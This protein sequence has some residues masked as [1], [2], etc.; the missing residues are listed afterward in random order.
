MPPTSRNP[1]PDDG[2][3]PFW[4]RRRLLWIGLGLFLAG[5]LIL[6]PFWHLVGQ[7][8]E[9]NYR[10]PSRLYGRIVRF[11]PRGAC[12]LDRAAAA[13]RYAGYRPAE[14]KDSLPAG[15]YRRSGDRLEVHSRRFVTPDG[16]RPGAIVEIRASRGRVAS[17][18]RDGRP[19]DFVELEPPVVASYYGPKLEERRPLRLEQMP[20]DL[21]NSVLAAEDD[22][23]FEHAG[24]SVRGVA[25]AA[26]V[27]LR[28]RGIRQGGST[29][30]QQLV[31]NLFLTQQRT[32]LRKAEEAVLAV[33]LET[34][35]DKREILESYLNEIYLGSSGGV[36]VLGMGAAARA[37]F[38]KDASD[39]DLAESATLA[40]MI[41]SPA[42]YS[43][44]AHPERSKERRD[45]VLRRLLELG[46]ADQARVNQAIEKPIRV[47]LEAPIRRRAP[48][49]SDAMVNEAGKRFRI[50]DLADA[51]FT[52]Y[53]TLDLRDQAAAQAAVDA[54]LSA[55]EAD[56]PQGKSPQPLEA[57]L[58]SVDPATGGILAYVGGRSYQKSQFDRASQ[59]KRQPGSAFKPIVYAQLFE[60]GKGTPA[61]F[62][63]DSPLTVD[64]A[65]KPWSPKND[66]GSFHGWVTVRHA[67]EHS[68]NPATA[69][70]GLQVGM[71]RVVDL[72]HAMGVTADMDPFPAVALGATSLAPVELTE[73]YATLAAG[74]V[75]PEIHGLAEVFDR[76]GK[77]VAGDTLPPPRR[78]LSPVAAYMV[79]TLLQGVVDRGTGAGV[80]AQGVDGAIAGKTG[81]TNDRRD[82]WFA[83]YS[84]DRTTVVWVGF[85][86]NS[87]THLSGARGALPLWARFI[88]AVRP[89]G[90][91]P[92]F[93]P[94]AGVRMAVIDP[95]TGLLAT[96][97]CPSVITEVF[98][99]GHVP[100]QLCDRHTDWESSDINAVDEDG[101]PDGEDS[102]YPPG[103]E[104]EGRRHPFRRWLSRVFGGPEGQP[105][106]PPGDDPGQGSPPPG[107]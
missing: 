57:A 98:P 64:M 46:L 51:G 92:P 2:A 3:I 49:F 47:D 28:G 53:S 79:T 37:F 29:L 50:T 19:A 4:R 38:G 56:G 89:P 65:G 42:P 84:T 106:Q 69:R 67:L 16:E 105:P 35:Y 31:K 23:F 58:V 60:S 5:L 103:Q 102:G 107:R 6:W 73:V 13:L 62:V 97:Y 27:N 100:S 96:E 83:G 101:E 26:W 8:D 30:T 99:E 20:Q 11:E 33:L 21:V 54:G 12:D 70:I 93:R 78:V 63:E 85:D 72:A 39:L 48:Y 88:K 91:F 45:W 66:D 71:D 55:L 80:R 41:R 17:L 18:T 43:P 44:V 86:D 90:G 32:L 75:R 14:A 10:Q 52:M 76:Y 81:T 7:F 95:S 82:S 1:L 15:R 59:A 77:R 94:P 22:S 34:R 25:R 24:I 40:G 61:S 87:P 9:R 74:G 36:S 104:G 68:Y